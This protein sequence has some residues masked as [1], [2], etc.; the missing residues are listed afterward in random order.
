MKIVKEVIILL[1]I[2]LLLAVALILS[3]SQIQGNIVYILIFALFIFLLM[4]MCLPEI[5]MLKRSFE[6]KPGRKDYIHGLLL[7]G[8]FFAVLGIMLWGIKQ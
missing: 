8:F 1:S 6:K 7:L 2:A 4:V 5:F 3:P